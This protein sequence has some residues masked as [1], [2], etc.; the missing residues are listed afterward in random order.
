[1]T[2]L[3]FAA[4]HP[5][6]NRSIWPACR[7]HSSKPATVLCGGQM[8][9]TD[10]CPADAWTLLCI[11]SGQCQKC[12]KRQRNNKWHDSRDAIFSDWLQYA[13]LLFRNG[14]GHEI[15][16][17]VGCHM[18]DYQ[19]HVV[20]DRD[21]ETDCCSN[22]SDNFPHQQDILRNLPKTLSAKTKY[23]SN[24]CQMCHYIFQKYLLS[25]YKLCSNINNISGYN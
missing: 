22:K 25:I 14:N 24:R 2:L 9:Q 12:I 10:G 21:S 6:S 18:Y 17:A 23:Q 15:L 1:M 5:C 19:T 4:E 20:N 8:G 16:Q 13:V 3:A 11:L 7:A